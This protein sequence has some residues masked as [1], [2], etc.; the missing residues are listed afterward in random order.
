MPSITVEN[1]LKTL[2]TLQPAQ[3]KQLVPLGELADAMTVTPGTVTTMLKN[4]DDAGYVDYQ[5]R[6][7]VRLTRDGENAALQVIR[8]HRLVELFLVEVMGYDWTEV[9]D[10]AEILEHAISDK[11]LERI[12]AMLGRPAA[13]PHGDPIPPARGKFRRPDMQSLDTAAP[14]PIEIARIRDHTPE[15]LR[16]LDAHGLVPGTTAQLIEHDTVGDLVRLV[17]H[18][19][20]TIALG[21]AAATKIF[22]VT[23]APRA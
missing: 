6:R 14:G 23:P 18:D 1:Y 16:Y 10:D 3:R 21:H 7:G 5:S 17:T 4:L 11:L 2:F 9:H 15:F 19:H 13:D 20:K 12:D 22:V 8:R